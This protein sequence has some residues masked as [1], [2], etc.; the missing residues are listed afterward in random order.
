MDGI[1]AEH[2]WKSYHGQAVLRDVT[3]RVAPGG[4]AVVRAPSGGGKTTLLRI[5]LR[6]EPPDRGTV[7]GP[8]RWGAVFQ[9]DRLLDHLDGL[10]NLRLALGRDFRADAAR[11]LLD[12]LGIGDG[13]GLDSGDGSG[14]DSGGG[15]GT[16]AGG[17]AGPGG[18][19]VLF[20][21]IR[22]GTVPG[23]GKRVRDWSGGMR[24]RLALA[25]ALLSP[26]EALSLDE[27]FAGLDAE[28]R[29]RCIDAVRRLG[30]GRTI[31]LASHD[32]ADA[33]DLD[34]ATLDLSALN[35]L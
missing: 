12:A 11:D 28:S 3:F 13:A 19:K 16:D 7:S 2:I 31:L 24:R 25:R 23:R 35:S 20:P 17:T 26:A 18:K 27:P 30:A 4:R 10:S 14:T 5:L 22:H 29:R 15:W 33:Q 6:L 21:G 32:P 1:A 8:V 34:A 9:G